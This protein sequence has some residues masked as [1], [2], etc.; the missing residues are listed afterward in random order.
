[1]KYKTITIACLLVLSGCM[2]VPELESNRKIHL[3]NQI[4]K[5]EY[6]LSNNALFNVEQNNWWTI[7]NDKQLNSIIDEILKNNRDLSISELNIEKI[8]ELIS[9]NKKNNNPQVELNGITQKQQLSEHGFYPPPLAGSLIDFSQISVKA[10]LNLDLFGKNSALVQEKKYQKEALSLRKK[11][12]ELALTIQAVKLYGYWHY[13]NEQEKITSEQIAYQEKIINLAKRKLSMGLTKIDEP[14]IT[15]NILESLKNAQ[16]DIITNKKNTIDQLSKLVGKVD[17]NI[18][19]YERDFLSTF[20][21]VSPPKLINS[22]VIINKPEI[23]YYLFNIYAQEANLKALKSDFYPSFAL[24]GEVGLQKIGFSN[25]L[26][27]GNIFA[28]LGPAIHLPILDSGRIT[29]NYKIAGID[30]NIFIENYN[31]SVINSYFDLNSQLFTTKQTFETMNNQNKAFKN[32]MKQLGLV[33]SSYQLGKISFYDMLVKK[34]EFL[35]R[36]KQTIN[37]HFMYFNSHIDLINNMGGTIKL[38]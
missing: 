10:N 32:D 9:L 38:N 19:I 3:N 35:N 20:E 11:A 16:L 15:E 29:T 17:S 31:K 25:L 13:L 23:G 7:F 8:D 27:S 18:E 5:T 28:N 34:N 1:M 24:T 22:S 33:I 37:N 36:K 6:S 21:K 26:S 4:G 2:T 14:L 12:T 30:L